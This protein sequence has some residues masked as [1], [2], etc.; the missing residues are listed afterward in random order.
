[1]NFLLFFIDFFSNPTFTPPPIMLC[2][3]LFIW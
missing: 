2:K 3:L 1:M